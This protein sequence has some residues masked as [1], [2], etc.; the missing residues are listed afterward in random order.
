MPKTLQGTKR[1]QIND[2]MTLLCFGVFFASFWQGSKGE[3]MTK[4]YCLFV[5]RP[6]IMKRRN[7]IT[8]QPYLQRLN[9]TIG[10]SKVNYVCAEVL[11][12]CFLLVIIDFRQLL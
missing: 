3:K 5:C 1:R 4:C 7:G 6:A 11:E 2:K 12:F 10:S 8:Q 9:P